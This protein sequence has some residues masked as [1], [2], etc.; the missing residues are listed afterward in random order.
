MPPP[1]D[2]PLPE[3]DPGAVPASA[4][5]P[6]P[7]DR[8]Y[9]ETL[10]GP[11]EEIIELMLGL[12]VDSIEPWRQR[13]LAESTPNELRALAHEVKGAAGTVGAHALTQTAA[14]AEM[15]VL[16]WLKQVSQN[17]Q[18]TDLAMPEPELQRLQ[19]YRVALLAQLE[20]VRV[21]WTQR[22]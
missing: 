6:A 2:Y 12:F 4:G 19:G 11:D 18:G 1:S 16:E 22:R 14:D 3:P 8:A 13:L 17:A 9:L 5:T 20:E 21:W 7:L 10:F 15:W